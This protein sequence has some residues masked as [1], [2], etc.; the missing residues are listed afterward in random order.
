MGTGLARAAPVSRRSSLRSPQR[1]RYR[2]PLRPCAQRACSMRRGPSHALARLPPTTGAAWP[3][4]RRAGSRRG[5]A[6][7]S[8]RPC[9]GLF[10][11]RW[12]CGRPAA[13]A[14]R[15][16]E[17]SS[18]SKQPCAPSQKLL[19]Q[20]PVLCHS[21]G[22]CFLSTNLSRRA[23]QYMVSFPSL[24]YLGGASLSLIKNLLFELCLASR[25]SSQLVVFANL[26]TN[27]DRIIMSVAITLF[28]VGF[29]GIYFNF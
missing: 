11:R 5:F 24:R 9:L 23:L 19:Y 12:S 22:D 15:T 14:E 16:A 20:T 21:T 27:C 2:V 29:S 8:R 18:S 3:P 25:S 13:M 26:C 7:Q 17:P 10:N 1:K 6:E 4:R 28:N